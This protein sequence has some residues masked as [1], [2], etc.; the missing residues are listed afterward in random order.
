MKKRL[1]IILPVLLAAAAVGVYFWAVKNHRN[2]GRLMVSGNIEATQVQLGFKI[3]GRLIE[4]LADEG[5]RVIAGQK[6]A[7]L[8]ATDQR[9]AVA[10]AEA[11]LA[12]RKSIAAELEAGSRPEEIQQAAARVQQARFAL[13]ELVRGSRVQVIADARSELDRAL[14]A[15]KAAASELELARSDNTRYAV[16]VQEE[17]V[18]QR[19]YDVVKTRL[20]AA[21][22]AWLEAQARAQSSRERLSLAQEGPRTEQIQQAR[23]ALRQAE[24]EYALVQAGP[25]SETIAQALAQVAVAEQTLSHARQQLAETELFSPIDGVVLSKSAEPGEFLNPGAPVVM[26]GDLINTWVRAFVNEKD[27]GRIRLNQPAQITTDAY[28]KEVFKGKIRFIDSQAAFTP[29]SV[30]T[31]EERVKLMYR[32]KI[33]AMNPDLKLKPGMPADALI[34][35]EP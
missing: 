19:D 17:V 14:A 26:V 23:A 8:D 12:Y 34:L 35:P 33:E 20:D 32:I 9:I 18:S 15:E 10:R 13:D 21:Y 4:R 5:D 27:L 31:F 7:V 6:I 24:A 25:R 29:K 30:Q 2:S 22:N 28:P 1:W 11:E 16:L 3:S